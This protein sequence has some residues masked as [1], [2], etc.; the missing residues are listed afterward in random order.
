MADQKAPSDKLGPLLP[1]RVMGRTGEKITALSLGGSHAEKTTSEKVSQEIIET[2]IEVGIRTFDNARLYGNG[3]SEILY[4]KY[5]T[6]KYRDHIY[7]TTK[8]HLKEA[9]SVRQELETSLRNMKTDRIDLWQIHSITSARDVDARWDAGVID[10]FLKAREEGL[11]RHIGFTG[12]RSPSAQLHLIKRLREAKT[13]FDSSLMPM[14]LVDP[15]YDSFIT[16]VLPELLKDNYGIWAM[17]TLAHGALIGAETS[18]RIK[19]KAAEIGNLKDV[20]LTVADMHHYAYS[21]PICNL[22]SGCLKPKEVIANAKT[23]REYKG[24]DAESRDQL[25]AKAKPYGTEGALEYYKGPPF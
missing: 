3:N 7:L 8:T 24:L 22:C 17:K 18:G 23:L 14:N 12:H 1:T 16:Q 19:G 9:K 13:P 6:P 2:A 25:L 20:G 4:G 10:E 15:H 21:L 11:V 5:L